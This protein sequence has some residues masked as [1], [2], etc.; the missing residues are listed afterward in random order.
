MLFHSTTKDLPDQTPMLPRSKTCEESMISL[1][2]L[3]EGQAIAM[4]NYD[5][6]LVYVYE[7]EAEDHLSVRHRIAADNK[8][9]DRESRRIY[10]VEG[11]GERKRDTGF[12]APENFWTYPEATVV[13][14]FHHPEGRK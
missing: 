4:G 6:G 2:G 12:N 9:P 10:E 7:L 1:K 13:R 3:D 8:W 5:N 14:C 11:I